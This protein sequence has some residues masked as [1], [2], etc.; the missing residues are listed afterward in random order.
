MRIDTIH[1]VQ[2]RNIENPLYRNLDLNPSEHLVEYKDLDNLR[3]EYQVDFGIEIR[4]VLQKGHVVSV[5]TI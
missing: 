4:D 1:L 2:D 3:K 5:L